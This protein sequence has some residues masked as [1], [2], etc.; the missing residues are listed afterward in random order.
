MDKKELDLIL[1]EGEGLTTEF[2]E[3]FSGKLDKDMVAF[4]NTRGGRILVGVNDK[5]SV[6]GEKLTNDLKAKINNV[7]RNCE[8]S[9]SLKNIKQVG[10]I[11]VL[12]VDESPE[13]PHS[14][15]SGFYRRLDAATQK[16]NQSELKLFFKQH[17]QRAPYEEE[18][19]ESVS[20]D[21]ISEEKIR[22]FLSEA[23]IHIDTYNSS[24][25]LHSLNLMNKM[26]VNNA[27]VLFFSKNPR[28]HIFHCET[29]LAAFKGVDRVN[30]YD[31]INVQEDLLTQFKQA[32]LFL[33]KHLNVRSE[34]V[35]VKR[36]DICEI[37]M[38][39]LREAVANAIIHRDYSMRGTSI[40][41]EVHEDR[42]VISNPGGIP[43]GMNIDEIKQRSIRR[44]ELIAD[45]FARVNQAER[46]ASGIKRIM[47]LVSE[48]ELPA[49]S[50]KSDSFF[51]ITFTRDPKFKV[52]PQA[53]VDGTKLAPSWH[54]AGTKLNLDPNV[55]QVIDLCRKPRLSQEL[56]EKMGWKD[57]T[58]FRKR[59][60]YPLL[61][62]GAIERT[63]PEKPKSPNQKY[64]T[65]EYG[66]GLLK[67][68]KK[69]SDDDRSSE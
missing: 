3:S 25:I 23:S 64:I 2:K 44:N 38:E 24:D 29:I 49:P 67:E 32:I 63:I 58:K 27:G 7:A 20:L 41:V 47:K 55:M 42:V 12:E 46:M 36:H 9:I 6:V 16:M 17:D 68:A 52:G 26:G 50:I 14:C 66:L 45:L 35:G 22:A 56:L 11:V 54:Q 34:I 4:A 30:I 31:R 10:E 62:I 69:D 51:E 28:K 21:D 48:A 60:I 19:C 13:K 59:F 18:I 5:G 33:T 37:P 53:G 65:T 43:D 39:A 8:P 15:A 40:M 1:K 57:R 61:E